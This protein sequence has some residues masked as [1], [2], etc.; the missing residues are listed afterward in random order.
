MNI[1]LAVIDLSLV[2]MVRYLFYESI[3][4]SQIDFLLLGCPRKLVKGGVNGLY[5]NLL[6]MNIGVITYNLL[7]NL[8]LTSWDIQVFIFF[9]TQ[10]DPRSFV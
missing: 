3:N 1:N 2:Y 6:I 9:L 7:T 5:R 4:F 10:D 8:L